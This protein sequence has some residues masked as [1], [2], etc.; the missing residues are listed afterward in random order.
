MG[1]AD[2]AP[3][4]EDPAAP[5]MQADA[6]AAATPGGR[7]PGDAWVE[8]AP[9]PPARPGAE[10]PAGPAAAGGQRVAPDGAA[11][12]PVPQA[13]AWELGPRPP[14]R[15]GAQQGRSGPPSCGAPSA[16]YVRLR[17][18]L[19]G[20]GL[21]VI[22]A[23][24]VAGPL[25]QP[26]RLHA[27]LACEVLVE[28]RR[29]AVDSIPDLGVWRALPAPAADGAAGQRAGHRVTELDAF[30]FQVRVPRDDLPLACLPAV[31][32][33]V[34]RCKG[35]APSEPIGP[36]SLAEQFG[37]ELREVASLEGVRLW[38]LDG[39]VQEELR[40]QLG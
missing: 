21:S 6:L 13:D 40:N 27:G 3:V 4:V 10:M 17:L 28:G 23:R 22:G 12:P 36:G 20:G 9:A 24:A 32:V 34:Y 11:M 8:D 35:D 31:R 30:E 33:A 37:R 1:G 38:E 7:D 19:D 29:V 26:L 14:V 18:R 25:L 16:G 15:L 2:A 5:S 39:E